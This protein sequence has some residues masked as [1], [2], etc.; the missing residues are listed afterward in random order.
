MQVRVR[1]RF[2]EGESG[3]PQSSLLDRRRVLCH[4]SPARSVVRAGA[5]LTTIPA[6]HRS[7][8]RVHQSLPQAAVLFPPRPHPEFKFTRQD[9]DESSA[10]SRDSGTF[11]GSFSVSFNQ[12]ITLIDGLDR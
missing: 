7:R 8:P 2:V 10:G 3:P 6:H 4:I 11:V 12:L 9:E 1:V 5:E